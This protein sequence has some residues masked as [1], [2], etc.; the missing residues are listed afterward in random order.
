MQIIHEFCLIKQPK[1]KDIEIDFESLSG[2]RILLPNDQ[3][4]VGQ[5]KS[6]SKK[7]KRI[8]T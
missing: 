8:V 5:R 3:A 2:Q 1:K 6:V 7:K 4:I